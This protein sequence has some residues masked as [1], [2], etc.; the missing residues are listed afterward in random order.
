MISS[1][2]VVWV[3]FPQTWPKPLV[4]KFKVP[5]TVPPQAIGKNKV[6]YCPYKYLAYQIK[7]KKVFSTQFKTHQG[8]LCFILQCI[9]YLQQYLMMI[10]IPF[11]VPMCKWISPL[12]W[13]DGFI[14]QSCWAVTLS[15]DGNHHPENTS[16]ILSIKYKKSIS[17]SPPQKKKKV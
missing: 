4:E 14:L 11:W 8:L 17:G 5:W 7:Y 10:P 13:Q 6:L 2:F 3:I 1:H 16:E 12:N 9:L 15:M